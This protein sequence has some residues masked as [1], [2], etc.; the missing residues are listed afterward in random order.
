M[1]LTQEE[2]MMIA[3]K[4]QLLLRRAIHES[5]SKKGKSIMNT[6]ERF[7]KM[8]EVQTLLSEWTNFVD[9]FGNE[10]AYTD[11]IIEKAQKILSELAL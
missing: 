5:V 4:Q 1:E 9:T 2:K 3:A 8:Q 7:D 6:K 10:C 11:S